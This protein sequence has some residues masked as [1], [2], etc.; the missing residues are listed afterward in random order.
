MREPFD[1]L[2]KGKTYATRAGCLRGQIKSTIICKG[3]Q[4]GKAPN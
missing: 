4:V 1:K 2:D 3:G